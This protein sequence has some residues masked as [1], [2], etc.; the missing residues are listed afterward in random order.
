MVWTIGNCSPIVKSDSENQ[1]LSV[2]FQTPVDLSI[3]ILIRVLIV[4]LRGR[5]SLKYFHV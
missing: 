2:F 3:Y 1:G 4:Q 5:N